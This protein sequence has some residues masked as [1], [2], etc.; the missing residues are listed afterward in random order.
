MNAPLG[1]LPIAY[2]ALIQSLP[3]LQTIQASRLGTAS[4]ME[5]FHGAFET[6][7]IVILYSGLEMNNSWT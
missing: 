1:C 6:P 2:L 5:S 7:E 4:W 3:A